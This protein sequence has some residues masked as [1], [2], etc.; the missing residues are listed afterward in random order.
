MVVCGGAWW[1]WA[2]VTFTAGW[3]WLLLVMSPVS[4]TAEVELEFETGVCVGERPRRGVHEPL[5]VYV[6]MY[7]CVYVCMCVCWS[8]G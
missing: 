8:H 7:V 5:C 1:W 2:G 3:R 6:C 4:R